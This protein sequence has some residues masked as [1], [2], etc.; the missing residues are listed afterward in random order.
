LSK[1]QLVAYER[2]RG[3]AVGRLGIRASVLDT[4]V[5]GKRQP[6]A[7]NGQGQPLDLP[8]PEPWPHPVDG[9]ALLSDMTDAVLKYVVMEPGSAETVA[10]WVMHAHAHDAF[11]ISP[12]LA[13]TSPE[14]RCGKTTA[15][16]VI[17][18]SVPRPLST[19]NTTAAAIFRTIEAARP[20]LL[21][22]EADTFLTNSEDIRGILNSGHRIR[23]ARAEVGGALQMV[24]DLLDALSGGEDNIIA[25]PRRRS[26]RRAAPSRDQS[27]FPLLPRV[28]QRPPRATPPRRFTKPFPPPKPGGHCQGK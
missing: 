8:T 11:Q 19:S 9:A 7:A 17:Q 15:L 27:V 14:M 2:E 10:L 3:S 4:L 22:D 28:R 20:T 13:I 1:L 6:E 21:I 18:S 24:A 16:D 26:A 12:R 25:M 23:V 5:K